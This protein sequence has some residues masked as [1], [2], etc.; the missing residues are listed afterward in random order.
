MNEK[1]SRFAARLLFQ[2]RVDIKKCQKRRTC[3]E[4]TIC[5]SARSPRAALKYA[6]RYG[7]KAQ[8]TYLNTEG[9]KVHF[10]F[11]GITD[12]L[13][14]GEECGPEEVWYDIRQML[15][16]MERRGTILPAEDFLLEQLE[17]S[18]GAGKK[19]RKRT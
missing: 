11:V 6:K 17:D 10:E 18:S 19:P 2:F 8:F 14:L 15:Q 12:I 16:P 13:R 7:E 3:E 9:L 4:R 5:F 1:R